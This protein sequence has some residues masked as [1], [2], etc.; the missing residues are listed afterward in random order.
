[1]GL[2]IEGIDLPRQCLLQ[3][4]YQAE[5][6]V[7][8]AQVCQMTGEALS[9]L[10]IKRSIK[11][12][13]LSFIFSHELVRD[14][15]LFRLDRALLHPHLSLQQPVLLRQVYI[16]AFLDLKLHVVLVTMSR[17]HPH[18]GTLVKNAFQSY[19]ICGK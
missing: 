18:I 11:G 5:Q 16:L 8:R 6:H 10:V 2:L 19:Q 15:L 14:E 9:C 12:A 13:V 3:A 7:D 1:M 17:H 4:L